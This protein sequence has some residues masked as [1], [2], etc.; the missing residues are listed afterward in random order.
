MI[1]EVYF[2]L[3]ISKKQETTKLTIILDGRLDTTS[4][5]Q[6]E[7]AIRTSLDGIS[8]LMLDFSK[9]EYSTKGI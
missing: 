3:T 1:G 7:E 6:L 9:L 2:M 5:P 4:A 8:T